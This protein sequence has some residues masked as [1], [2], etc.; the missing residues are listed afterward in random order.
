MGLSV[1]VAELLI[2]KGCDPMTKNEDGITAAMNAVSQVRAFIRLRI[3]LMHQAC[4]Q[5]RKS[6]ERSNKY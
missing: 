6:T 3:S 5:Y 4:D 1:K 2:S